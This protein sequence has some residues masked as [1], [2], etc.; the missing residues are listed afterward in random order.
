[1]T[2]CV[3]YNLKS[4]LSLNKIINFN[5]KSILKILKCSSYNER[6]QSSSTLEA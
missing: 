3:Y 4:K 5:E 2:I 6:N 1:M